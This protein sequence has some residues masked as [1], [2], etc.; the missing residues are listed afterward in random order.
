M[1]FGHAIDAPFDRGAAVAVGADDPEWIAVTAEKALRIVERILVVDAD[2]LQPLS[3]VNSVS[4][5]A[6]SS[7]G[8]K[9]T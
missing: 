3:L 2:E 1:R 5:G 8:P 6:S 4:S 9:Q 7:V